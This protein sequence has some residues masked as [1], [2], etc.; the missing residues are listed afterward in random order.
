MKLVR[1]TIDSDSGVLVSEPMNIVGGIARIFESVAKMMS[2]H[3]YAD[4]AFSES[5]TLGLLRNVQPMVEQ[6][7]TEYIALFVNK[8]KLDILTQE[9]KVRPK[10]PSGSQKSC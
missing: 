10:S 8:W 1:A 5:C 9:I 6:I 3:A 7:G 4:Q 2:A